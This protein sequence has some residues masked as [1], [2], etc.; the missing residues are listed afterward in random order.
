M[1]YELMDHYIGER[2]KEARV[3][4]G[5]TM[6]E[7]GELLGLSKQRIYSYETGKASLPFDLFLAFCRIYGLNPQTLFEDAQEYMRKEAFK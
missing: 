6:P 1:K 3:S 2:L 5:R 7:I 4:Q